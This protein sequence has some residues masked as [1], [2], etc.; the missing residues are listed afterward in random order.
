ML[1]G[2]PGRYPLAPLSYSLLVCYFLSIQHFKRAHFSVRMP[3]V[4][5]ED[6][7]NIWIYAS[8]SSIYFHA[9]THTHTFV[10]LPL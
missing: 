1:T 5:A 7:V 4:M 8:N 6:P 2:L 3:Q 9:R 10:L